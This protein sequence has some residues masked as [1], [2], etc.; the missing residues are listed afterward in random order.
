VDTNVQKRWQKFTVLNAGLLIGIFASLFV[1]PASTSIWLVA[2]VS[3]AIVGVMN[4]LLF[5]RLRSAEAETSVND[6]KSSTVIIAVGFLIFLI[7]LAFGLA[8]H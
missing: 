1:I 7:D 3:A 2:A 6:S 4:V 5:R 8:H